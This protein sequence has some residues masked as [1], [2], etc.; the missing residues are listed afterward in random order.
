MAKI[1]VINVQGSEESM[2]KILVNNNQNFGKQWPKFWS[3]QWP[4]N[5]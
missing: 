3:R 4:K 5:W 1:L 2:A